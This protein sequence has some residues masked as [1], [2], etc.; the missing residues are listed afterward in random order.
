M[1]KMLKNSIAESLDKSDCIGVRMVL[2]ECM[3][4]AA[5]K[6][7]VVSQTSPP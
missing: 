2:I 3:Q 1:M 4:A 7:S 5:E 6:E